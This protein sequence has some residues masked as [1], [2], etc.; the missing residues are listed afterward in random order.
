MTM[1]FA[2][3]EPNGVTGEKAKDDRIVFETTRFSEAQLQLRKINAGRTR[4]F[5]YIK[6]GADYTEAQL[7]GILEVD[8]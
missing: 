5:A 1:R 8:L 6:F 7:H 3:K 2:I 4:G